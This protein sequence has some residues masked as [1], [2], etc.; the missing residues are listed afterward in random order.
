M[1]TH[2]H[3]ARCLATKGFIGILPPTKSILLLLPEG[4]WD[5]LRAGVDDEREGYNHGPTNYLI[6]MHGRPYMYPC[7]ITCNMQ[8]NIHVLQNYAV[9]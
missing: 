4:Y 9:L 1:H 5:D 3:V 6:K 2:I 8:H 7:S